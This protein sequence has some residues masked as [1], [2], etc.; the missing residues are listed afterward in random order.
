M[1]FEANFLIREFNYLI[2]EAMYLI[3][4]VAFSVF[5]RQNARAPDDTK[6]GKM[7][8]FAYENL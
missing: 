7:C 3:Q 4:F 8:Y 5:C 2:H 6:V 1:L